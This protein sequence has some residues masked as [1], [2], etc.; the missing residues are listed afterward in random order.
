M[1][2]VVMYMLSSICGLACTEHI[3]PTM[4]HD[5]CGVNACMWSVNMYNGP[6]VSMHPCMNLYVFVWIWHVNWTLTA[7]ATAA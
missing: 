6:N 7:C 4:M 5:S 2:A 1:H 3:F